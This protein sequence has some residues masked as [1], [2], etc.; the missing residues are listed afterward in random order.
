MDK[1]IFILNNIQYKV[2]NETLLNI[3]N[4][5]FHRG[6][7]Y[8]LSGEM[9]SGKSLIVNILNK[10]LRAD[11]GEIYYENDNLQNISISN[12][13]KDVICVA[14]ET[15]RPFFKS[16]YQYIYSHVKRANQID[17]VDKLVNNIITVMY[18][19]QSTL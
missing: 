13:L 12:Y 3:K 5:E 17:K 14:Q 9:G 8:M 1:P 16:V 15:K 4:F 6:A 11:S 18:V 10:N 19:D 7:C 2:G